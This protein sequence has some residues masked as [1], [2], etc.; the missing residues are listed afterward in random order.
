M[1]SPNKD[2]KIL[3][4]CRDHK[5]RIIDTNK[6]A[7]RYTRMNVSLFQSPDDY[8]LISDSSAMRYETEQ[9]YTLEISE[10]EL[11]RIADFEAKVFNHME[12]E[13]H[14]NLFLTLME[15]K[16]QEKRLKNKYPAVLKAYEQYSLMLKLAQSGEI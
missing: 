6:R 16:E 13:G 10:S 15:Q 8:N 5:V 1:I 7:H 2:N 11:E 9:L 14:Y 12:R 4:F 3:E